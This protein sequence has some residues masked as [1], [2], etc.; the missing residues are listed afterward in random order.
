[1]T[2]DPNDGGTG[3]SRGRPPVYAEETPEQRDVRLR[4]LARERQAERRKRLLRA[5]KDALH[6]RDA[7]MQ[8]G[9]CIALGAPHLLAD[10]PV[11]LL[12]QLDRFF[13]EEAKRKATPE[14]PKPFADVL[15]VFGDRLYE[16]DH[17]EWREERRR[18]QEEVGQA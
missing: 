1:M 6:Y 3:R 8:L 14:N 16:I 5:E 18:Q 10:V 15:K 2:Q 12:V 13:T 17:A 9:Q 11:F 4:K 7:F